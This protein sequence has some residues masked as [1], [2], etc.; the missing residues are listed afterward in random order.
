[1]VSWRNPDQQHGHF[2]F[3]TYAQAVLEAREA[4]A[5]IAEHA[6]VHL[7]AAC[8]GGIIAAGTAGH[9]AAEG[10]LSEVAS[11]TLLVCAIDNEQAGTTSA[12]TTK[13][14]A[15]AAIAQSARKG[16]LEGEALAS[17]FAWLRPNDLIWNYLVNNYLLGKEPPAFD[18]LYWNQDTVRLAAGL[19]RDFVMLALDNALTRPGGF[20][21]LGSDVDLSKV[22]VDSYI[23]A[24]STDHIVPWK[25]AYRSTQLLGGETRFV[26]S[27]SGHIQALINPPAR[28][29]TESRASFRVADKH[30]AEVREWQEQAVTKRGSWWADYVE[31]LAD[32]SGATKAA[33]SKLGSRTHK[34]QSKAPGTYV[35]AA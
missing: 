13:Q 4:V 6:S 34:A 16:Y 26:L 32:R 1:M 9:L 3:D 31:W 5:Q 24:G 15:A 27:T 33:P 12:F 8:S 2:D 35:H 29:G 19:H 20:A 11:L 22:G 21:V 14:V 23:V 30:P 7:M 18:I 17:V 28:E 10:R 25:N